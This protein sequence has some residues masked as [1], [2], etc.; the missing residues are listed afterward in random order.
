MAGAGLAGLTAAY[1]LQQ[2]GAEVTVLEARERVGGRVWSRE[3]ANGAVVEMGAE[4]LLAGNTAVRE[5]AESFGLDLWDKGMRYGRREPRGADTSADELKAAAG[6]VAEA[7]AD[8][9]PDLPADRFLAGLDIP[10]PAREA[11]LARVEISSANAAGLVAAR[12]LAGLAHVDDDP[13]PSIAG[14]NAAP[15]AGAG[16][17]AGPG[18]AAALAGGAHRLAAGRRRARERRRRRAGGRRLRGGAAREHDRHGSPS[19]RRCPRRSATRSPRCATATRPSCSC[20]CAA[21]RRRAR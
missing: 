2:A 7:L 17:G 3:L 8:A 12:D 11:L 9:D 20:R 16:R 21:P 5:L 13:A 10:A 19:T 14:G 18:A 4:F 1:E 15:A 6:V